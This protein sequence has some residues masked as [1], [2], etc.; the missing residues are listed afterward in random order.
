MEY[1]GH[2]AC[3]ACV[4]PTTE[5]HAHTGIV[6]YIRA[7]A[8]TYACARCISL[9]LPPPPRYEVRPKTM[10]MLMLMLL[11]FLVLKVCAFSAGA[12]Y[13]AL[14][15]TRRMPLVGRE[16]VPADSVHQ[17]QPAQ[18]ALPGIHHVRVSTSLSASH[19]G[20]THRK[21]F[22]L[23]DGGTVLLDWCQPRTSTVQRGRDRVV[24]VLPGLTSSYVH[25][26]YKRR[27]VSLSAFLQLPRSIHTFIR[28][29]RVCKRMHMCCIKCTR[30]WTQ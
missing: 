29:Y 27:F 8:R 12:M 19:I 21:R 11:P 20:P 4:Y 28:M 24:L 17:L 18:R 23:P 22:A 26:W 15:D 5:A 14:R 10:L 9:M 6:L 25:I 2:G 3:C 30:L 16:R 1:L 7:R 13:S